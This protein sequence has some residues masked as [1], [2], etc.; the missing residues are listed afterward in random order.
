MTQLGE[1]SFDSSPAANANAVWQFAAVQVHL[2]WFD[3]RGEKK[4][5]D[6]K[7]IDRKLLRLA[8][9]ARL[10]MDLA[11]WGEYRQELASLPQSSRW[12]LDIAELTL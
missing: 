6:R 8:P 9:V 2:T 10:L 11:E 1:R 7:S 4:G 3:R 12:M 5:P